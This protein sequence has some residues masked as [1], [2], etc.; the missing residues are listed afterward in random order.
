MAQI[1]YKGF[2]CYTLALSQHMTILDV[3]NQLGVSWDTS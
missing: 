2:E 3:A 1:L